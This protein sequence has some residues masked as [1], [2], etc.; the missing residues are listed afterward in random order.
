SIRFLRDVK[1]SSSPETLGELRPM[2]DQL[3]S[4][5]RAANEDLNS[6]TSPAAQSAS[7]ARLGAQ[8]KVSVALLKSQLDVRK[9]DYTDAVTKVKQEAATLHAAKQQADQWQKKFNTRAL[10]SQQFSKKGK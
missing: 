3:E 8:S 1:Q 6:K 9:S 2:L 10:N 5:A 4:Q 7:A